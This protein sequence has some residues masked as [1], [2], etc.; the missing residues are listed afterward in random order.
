MKRGL[1]GNRLLEIV[2]LAPVIHKDEG[3]ESK[4]SF[5]AERSHVATVLAKTIAFTL[6]D[7]SL[8]LHEFRGSSSKTVFL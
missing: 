8:K 2:H 1:S 6:K 4:V 7:F 5:A 3:C